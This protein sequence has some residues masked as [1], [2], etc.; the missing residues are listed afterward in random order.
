MRGIKEKFGC[1]Y[2]Y[3]AHIRIFMHVRKTNDRLGL[4]SLICLLH[5]YIQIKIFKIMHIEIKILFMTKVL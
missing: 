2:V 4:R 1:A 5:H 3:C